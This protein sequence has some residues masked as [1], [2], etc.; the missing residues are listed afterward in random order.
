MRAGRERDAGRGATRAMPGSGVTGRE[1]QF[2]QRGDRGG[3]R[4]FGQRGDRGGSAKG[5]REIDPFSYHSLAMAPSSARPTAFPDVPLV[6]QPTPFS[7][8][9]LPTA[10]EPTV[11][12][13]EGCPPPFIETDFPACGGQRPKAATRQELLADANWGLVALR[14]RFGMRRPVGKGR[15]VQEAC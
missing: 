8:L 13:A 10:W 12:A 11:R 5:W 15:N 14:P 2:G 6:V 7:V 9:R 1:R 4:Q 3:R